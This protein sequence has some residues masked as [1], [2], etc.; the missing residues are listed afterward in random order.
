METDLTAILALFGRLQENCYIEE[1]AVLNAR[2]NGAEDVAALN[3][4]PDKNAILQQTVKNMYQILK[5]NEQVRR[6]QATTTTTTTTNQRVA[7]LTALL[8]SIPQSRFSVD[9]RSPSMSLRSK[10]NPWYRRRVPWSIRVLDTHR[11]FDWP[12][13]VFFCFVCVC[14][15]CR[16]RPQRLREIDARFGGSDWTAAFVLARPT[17]DGTLIVLG[18]P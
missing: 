5:I 2:S 4:K 11:P 9:I 6:C 14:P 17:T 18:F 8:L 3:N 1:L 10:R 16:R 7:F 13:L 12:F 15:I